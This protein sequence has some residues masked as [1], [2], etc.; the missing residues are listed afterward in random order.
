MRSFLCGFDVVSLAYC[1]N[2][3]VEE[4]KATPDPFGCLARFVEAQH[5]AALQWRGWLDDA[6]LVALDA[7]LQLIHEES[8]DPD[9]SRSPAAD[10]GSPIPVWM[11][12]RE[13]G[14]AP[15]TRDEICDVSGI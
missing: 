4:A 9:L 5:P 2:V 7:L 3:S 6:D 11:R 13:T 15:K 8:Y 10:T 14:P 12:L 1:C